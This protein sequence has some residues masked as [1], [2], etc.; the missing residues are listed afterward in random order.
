[1]SYVR[2]RWWRL[3]VVVSATGLATVTFEIGLRVIDAQAAQLSLFVVEDLRGWALRP[4]F[5][6][7]IETEARVR[8]EINR[9]GMRDRDHALEKPAEIVRVAVLGDSFMQGVNVPLEKT[10]ASFLERDLAGCAPTT[11]Q[12]AEVLNFGVEGYG[13]AQE[14]LTYRHRAA[15]YRP[16]IVILAVYTSND[17]FNNHRALN[18]RNDMPYFVLR[19]HQLQLEQ[20]PGEAPA[21]DVVPWYHAARMSL[22]SRSVTARLVWDGYALLR[23]PFVAPQLVPIVRPDASVTERARTL[24]DPVPAPMVRDEWALHRPPPRS[25][26]DEAWAVTEALITAL[27]R[28]VAQHGAE[29]W[30]VTLSNSE[31]VDP[32][33]SK[34]TA[35]ANRL[36]VEDLFYP[37]RRLHDFATA[38][39]IPVVSLAEPLAAYAAANGVYLNGGYNEESPNGIGHWNEAANQLAASMVGERLCANSQRLAIQ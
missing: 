24:Y 11:S 8:V 29:F 17:I 9:D 14:L 34:R 35:M 23:A 28:E 26:I 1:M 20:P 30:L 19:N 2:R 37:D 39:G 18:E 5:K 21:A 12:P 3:F 31:Q 36:G 25:V 22:T 16:D 32:D 15:R 13:T 38:Q 10:F 6:G 27:S 33:V 4:G 7:W